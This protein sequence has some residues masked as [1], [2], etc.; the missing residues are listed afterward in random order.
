MIA[1][2]AL[3]LS[4]SLVLG[5]G[6][7][8]DELTAATVGSLK[9]QVPA[10][11]QRRAEEGSTRYAV[12]SGE[13]YFDVTVGK[14]QRKGGM[15]AAVCLKKILAGVGKGFKKT[16]LGGQPAAFKEYVD[17]DEQG[18]KFV[19]LT[20]LGCD[21]TTTWSLSFHMLQ[22]KRDRFAPLAERISRSLEYTRE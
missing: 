5:E 7:A 3:A 4:L 9:L 19:E 21:G 8:P 13:A 12:P 22:E 2:A 10:A 14:V 18:K 15:P 11:W 6:A 1:H 16:K 20:Y 17:A